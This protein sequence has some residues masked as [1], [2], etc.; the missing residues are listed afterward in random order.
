MRSFRYLVLVLTVFS[1]LAALAQKEDWLPVGRQELDLKEVPGAPGAPAIQLYYAHWIDDQAHFVFF[2]KRI[3]ILNDKG[4]KYA[5]VEIPFM[6]GTSIGELKART[7]HPDGGIV[8]FTG[9]PFEKVAVK[10]R[11]VKIKT[12]NFTLPEATVGSI[13]EYKYRLNQDTGEIY[14]DEWTVQH[15]LYTV[16]ESFR[17]KA[18][19]G[20]F[21]T[22]DG[23]EAA[24]V[25][26][27]YSKLP[28][29]TKPRLK[30]ESFEME[31]Q[32][33]PAF[34]AEEYMP[35]EDFYKPHVRFFYGGRDILSPDKFWEST[36]RKINEEIERF[37]GNSGDVRDA[38]VQEAGGES[39]PEKKLRKLYARAQQIRNLS[40][41][42]RRTAEERKKEN[43]K[44]NHNAADVLKHGYGDRDDITRLFV[45]LARAGGFQASIYE[46]SNRSERFFDKGV[47]SRR[48]FDTEVA[49]VNVNGKEIL[50]DPG[51]RFCPYGLMRWIRTATAALKTDKKGGSFIDLPPS[52]YE[53]AIVARKA[54]MTLDADGSLKGELTVQFRGIEALE[55]RLDAVETDEAG[56][57]KA[58]EDEAG[59]WLPASAVVKLV[60]AKPWEDGNEPLSAVFNVEIPGY[61]SSAGK[62]VVVPANLFRVTRKTAF[63]HAERKFPVYFP[64]AFSELDTINIRFPAGYTSEGAPADR[65]ANL[66]FAQY[67]TSG[68]VSG[69]QWIVQRR[70]LMNGMY[71]DLP[72]YEEVKGFFNSVAAGD[73]QQLIL[74]T[75]GGDNAQKTN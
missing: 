58:L 14:S 10:G 38:A 41:E 16:R 32:N 43:L 55:H 50:L 24:Q 60:D 33:I 42:R 19:Q 46:V 2:Y 63:A 39:D 65:A 13:V 57:R 49:V 54:N 6:D 45:A 30:G 56:R 37:I 40:Y 25:S 12:R 52:N 27:V 59:G 8:E 44:S 61:A 64:Y 62:R 72:K 26:L 73:E 35:P 17:L 15:E 66:P 7:I 11:G 47:L 21:V 67:Q 28:K 53:Q 70:L 20:R 68:Q 29:D 74:R 31:A 4:T 5:D 34:E 69:N 23:D 9:K 36:G 22:A 51:T 3:K 1:S 48:E 71:F 75:G 18:Y